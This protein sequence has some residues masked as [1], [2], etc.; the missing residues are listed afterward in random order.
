MSKRYRFFIVLAVVAVCFM[1]LYPTIRWYFM[2][3]K[4]DQT[5]A[6]GSRE[7][8]KLYSS[9][10]AQEDLQ[11]LISLARNN[12]E[13]PAESDFLVDIAKKQVKRT[14]GTVPETWNARGVLSVF[15]NEREALDAIETNY[16]DDIFGLKTLQERA[17]QLGLDL[18]GG[19]SIV[20]RADMEAL[21]ER[22]GRTPDAADRTDAMNR[23]LE[24]LNSRIDR[25]GLTE[26]VIRLQGEDE[27]YVEIPGS[28]DPER[29]NSIIMGEGTLAFHLVDDEATTAFQAYYRANPTSTFDG[30]GNLIDPSIIPADSEILGLYTKDRYGLDEFVDYIAVKKEPGLDGTHIE[31]VSV[32]RDN[33]T[34]TPDVT[35][36]LDSE[37]AVIFATLTAE[38][39]QKRLAVVMD[40]RVKSAATINEPIPG[41]SVQLTGFGAE[42]ADNIAL[43]LRTAAFPVEL[44][45][46]SQQAIG[47]S[48]GEDTIRQGLYALL[49]GLALVM[50]FMLVFYKGSGI[51]AVVAQVLNIFIMFSV[52]SAFSFTLT[53]PSIAGFILTIGMAVDANVVVFERIKEELRLGK[54]RK[55]SVEA[56]FSKAFWAIM[57]SNITTFIAA[58]FLSQLGSGPIRG[59][60]VSLAIGVFSSVFTALFVSR[61]IF[62]FGTDVMK[63]QKMSIDW[64]IK[65]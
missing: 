26:P 36:Q 56:G 38:N 30:N 9:R 45:V 21:G 31:N 61:L 18:S 60:A 28:A 43:V 15:I 44:E 13:I 8:I 10:L 5:L 17:V 59:F 23:V 33:L 14:K 62:D 40:D 53:L 46:V 49:G 20:L 41:G 63:Q 37:G 12:G 16:R 24:V 54:G 25:F 58:L 34:G 3:P 52:L 65:E 1:F 27:V 47:S 2:I 11:Q 4:E 42:E 7:Q 48:L 64:R 29:I 19:M 35:F 57:D 6:L 50:I 39:V 51:N 22:L 55:A 32:Q